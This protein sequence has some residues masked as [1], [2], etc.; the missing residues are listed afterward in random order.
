MLPYRTPTVTAKTL[1]TIDWLSG[2]RLTVATGSGWLAAE[3]CAL[4]V[5]FAERGARTKETIQVIRNL[6]NQSQSASFPPQ[7][8]PGSTAGHDRAISSR[9]RR[10][11][12]RTGHRCREDLPATGTT[13]TGLYSAHP[14]EIVDTI[15]NYRSLGLDHLVMSW[16]DE[17]AE[18]TIR[19]CQTLAERI[20]LRTPQ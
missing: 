5:P 9:L 2:G 18:L 14:D 4:G 1:A 6:W 7:R 11:R 12:P 20:D 3:F 17:T 15:G 16:P 19:R 8:G 13:T 10:T